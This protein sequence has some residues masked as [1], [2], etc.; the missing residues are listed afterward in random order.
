MINK[1]TALEVWLL[2]S[3]AAVASLIASLIFEAGK[4]WRVVRS[5][6]KDGREAM[7]M[8]GNEENERRRR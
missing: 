3:L 4:M 8:K 2:S 6:V 1:K 5:N 7:Y